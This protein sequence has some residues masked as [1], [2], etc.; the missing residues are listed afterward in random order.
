[1]LKQ[2]LPLRLIAFFAAAAGLAA[3][4]LTPH[5]VEVNVFSNGRIS[6][7]Q[8]KIVEKYLV[9]DAGNIPMNDTS[10]FRIGSSQKATCE[11]FRDITLKPHLRDCSPN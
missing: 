5:Q 11:S 9:T 1:M 2:P 4:G 8:G 6:D 7:Q 3:Y 10:G